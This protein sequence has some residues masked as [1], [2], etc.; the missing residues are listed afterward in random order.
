[1]NSIIAVTEFVLTGLVLVWSGFFIFKRRLPWRSGQLRWVKVLAGLSL[2]L[3]IG[4]NWFSDSITWRRAPLNLAVVVLAL[5]LGFLEIRLRRLTNRPSETEK[6]G[7]VLVRR[8]A[9]SVALLANGLSI[10][11]FWLFPIIDLPQ[12]SGPYTVGSSAFE[13]QDISRQGVYNDAVDQNRRLMV[14]VWYPVD[15][16]TSSVDQPTEPWLQERPLIAAFAAYARLPAFM[17]SH[18]ARTGT[19][20]HWQLPLSANQAAWPVVVISHGW[21]GARL[22]HTDLAEELAS[23]GMVV[24]SI[25]HTFG[26]LSVSFPDG[27]VVPLEPA[28]LPPAEDDPALFAERARCLV[29]TYAADIEAVLASVR[30][31]RLPDFLVGRLD[32]DRIALVG[33]STGGGAA[34]RVAMTDTRLAAFVGFDAWLEPLEADVGLG[35]TLPQLHFGSDQWID[36]K[37]RPQVVSWQTVSPASTFFYIKDSAHMDFAMLRHITR[38]ARLIGWGGAINQRRFAEL[39]NGSTG[40]WLS[41]ILGA[42]EA[43]DGN[44]AIRRASADAVIQRI[45]GYPEII[46]LEL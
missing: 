22:V 27:S 16:I 24:L 5:A 18:L 21:T 8:L 26:S 6:S 9:G 13:L 19:N 3:Y 17:M 31:D 38:A 23:R 7:L 37:N 33:H 28:A 32:T 20:S 35:A 10:L 30:L 25:D 2:V 46:S 15:P 42:D 1:M 44:Q 45:A 12:P 43:A 11:A 39:V 41:A 4:L 40:A 36:G 29:A 14:Q 34:A